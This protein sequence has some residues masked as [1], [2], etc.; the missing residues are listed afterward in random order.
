M[1]S[2]I[3]EICANCK[4]TAKEAN[5]EKLRRCTQ[6]KSASFCGSSCQKN[7]FAYHKSLCQEIKQVEAEL[8]SSES[9]YEPLDENEKESSSG[10]KLLASIHR[11]K[12]QLARMVL[13]FAT[14]KKAYERVNY[15]LKDIKD[16]E[17]LPW[18]SF[19][20][21]LIGDDQKSYG[22]IQDVL[23]EKGISIANKTVK[24]DH[25]TEFCLFYKKYEE[26]RVIFDEE[27]A[28][29]L[30]AM[31]YKLLQGIFSNEN[32]WR[33][34]YT[35]FE[36]AHEDSR[37]GQFYR[38]D[39]L[40]ACLECFIKG[41]PSKF[42][43]RKEDLKAEIQYYYLDMI[44]NNTPKKVMRAENLT[45]FGS[46]DEFQQYKDNLTSQLLKRY[47]TRQGAELKTYI[48][49]FEE[50]LLKKDEELG[51]PIHEDISKF[52]A[53]LM[54]RIPM[55]PDD[56]IKEWQLEMQ[57]TREFVLSHP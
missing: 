33:K 49:T 48:E 32:Q 23:K 42:E 29:I 9:K 16:K 25:R 20:Y 21:M 14:D 54:K 41:N 1:E 30:M 15:Y 55:I 12:I 26:K 37:S 3:E 7:N 36:K 53:K 46:L 43:Q 39:R 11:L 44:H 31:K 34:M 28:W 57:Q 18:K 4:K 35:K 8:Q 6:C 50:K 19:M 52:V 27:Y 38:S 5:L 13:T 56:T 2:G 10:T 51:M 45:N 24:E 47:F 40:M 22:I 17:I